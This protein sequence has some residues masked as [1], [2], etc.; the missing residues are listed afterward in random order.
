M[1]SKPENN[2][3]GFGITLKSYE[4]QRITLSHTLELKFFNKLPAPQQPFGNLISYCP[5]PA[6]HAENPPVRSR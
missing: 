3:K 2:C 4:L 5:A 6:R 1:E